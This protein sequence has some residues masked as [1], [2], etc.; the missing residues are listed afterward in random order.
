[1]NCRFESRLGH[2]FLCCVVLWWYKPC[3]CQIWRP[4]SL[5]AC[6]NRVRNFYIRGASA[7]NRDVEARK[8]RYYCQRTVSILPVTHRSFMSVRFSK[9]VASHLLWRRSFH[10]AKPKEV[11]G[12]STCGHCHS[13][14]PLFRFQYKHFRS[15]SHN[16][17]H[18]I[19]IQ[20]F[21]HPNSIYRGLQDSTPSS[22]TNS[23]V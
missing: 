10:S 3:D 17:A 18:L 15:W 4:R 6:L 9:L 1:M 16:I 20:Q 5:T 7:T 11:L 23:V 21:I 2:A 14:V 19:I 13:F 22:P 8:L 12:Q